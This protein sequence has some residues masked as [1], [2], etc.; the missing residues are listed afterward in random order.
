MKEYEQTFLAPDI[1]LTL[2]LA[3][4]EDESPLKMRARL[5]G[6]GEYA[7]VVLQILACVTTLPEFAH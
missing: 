6:L 2:L 4:P 1:S 7:D 5:T 3:T